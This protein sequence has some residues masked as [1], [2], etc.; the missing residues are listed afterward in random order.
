VASVAGRVEVAFDERAATD[1]RASIRNFSELSGD[2]ARAVRVQSRNMDVIADGMRS[3][4]GSLN[5]AALAIRNVA[6]R[7]D[8]SIHDEQVTQMMADVSRAASEMRA[9]TIQLHAMADRLEQ[10][11]QRVDRVVARTDSVMAKINAGQGSLGLLVNDPSL[12]RSSDTLMRE[13]RKALADFQAN[14]KKYVNVRIF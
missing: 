6:T 1:L 11:G 4:V 12:Y 5:D 14:P 7:A 2:L 8:T 9:A 10:S 3:G 13:A